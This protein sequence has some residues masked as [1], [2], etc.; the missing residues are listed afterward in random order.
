M[1]P[2]EVCPGRMAWVI[3]IGWNVSFQNSNGK[4]IPALNNGL[5]FFLLQIYSFLLY[6]VPPESHRIFD[7]IQK[8]T[9]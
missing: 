6:D 9:F 4:T 7:L 8:L 3:L 1:V 5:Q 2:G